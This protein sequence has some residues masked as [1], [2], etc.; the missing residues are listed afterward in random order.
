MGIDSIAHQ[1]IVQLLN[2]I[3]R[4]PG[5]RSIQ[6]QEFQN[7]IHNAT[8]NDIWRQNNFE[9]LVRQGAVELGL[10]IKC[11][12]CSSWTWHP[13]KELG[14]SVK[15]G[16]CLQSF[17]FPIINPSSNQHT[18]WSYRLV[19]PFALPDYARGGYAAAL[20]LRFFSAVVGKID[21]AQITWSAGQELELGPKSKAEADVVLWYQRKQMFGNDYP[22]EIVFGEVKSFGRE[23]FT[24]DDVDRMRL[25]SERFPGAAIVFATMKEASELSVD[26]VSRIR[27]FAEWGREYL[28]KHQHTR[29]PVVVLTGTELFAAHH[30]EQAWNERGG[31]HAEFSE[32]WGFRVENLR[33]LANLTQQ[34]YLEMPPYNSWLEEKWKRK[35]VRG[36]GL[37]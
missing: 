15:C 9:R 16:L 4:R 3:S 30:L 21:D 6:H 37:E 23:V 29:A 27:K 18:R 35:S 24:Q 1:E 13:L 17:P 12:K 32:H 22:A 20:T 2:E 8:K 34:L 26:E 10:E 19:G 31:K 25:I 5:S 33:I 14:Y 28:R 7:R 36:D 11:E